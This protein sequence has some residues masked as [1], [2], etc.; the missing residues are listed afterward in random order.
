MTRSSRL[1]VALRSPLLLAVVDEA[2]AAGA[3]VIRGPIGRV[4]LLYLILMPLWLALVGSYRRRLAR[5][6]QTDLVPLLSA[7]ACPLL[8]MALIRTFGTEMLLKDMPLVVGLVVL[9]RAVTY[10]VQRVARSRSTDAE[11]TLILG[12]GKLGCQVAEALLQHPEYGMKPVGFVDGFPNDSHLPLPVVGDIDTFD[13]TVRRVGAVRV[14]V[15]FGA[16]REA[17]LVDVLRASAEAHVEVHILPRLFELGVT[18]TG[19]E[20]DIVWGL[21]LQHARRAALRTPAWRTKRV[22]D[23]AVSSVALFLLWPLLA[24]VALAVR[25]TSRGPVLFRQKRLGQRGQVVEIYK[26][27]S[28]RVTTDGD[29]RWGNRIDDRVTRVGRFLR[30]TSMDE[31]PQLL[32]VLKGD[33]SLV[34]PR[35]E[36]PFF[37]DQFNQQVFRYRDRL[38][39]PVGLTGWAQVHGLRGDTSIEE[40]ARFDNYYIEHWSLWF[41]LVILGRTVGQV[42]REMTSYLR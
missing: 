13:Q 4:G 1:W 2:A 9:G 36:R 35:P 14:I 7:L 41:D 22:I 42:V 27:R 16:N 15:A 31:L 6:F 40:R 37:A 29:T 24:G 10:S 11:P 26:F 39:V 33:M 38:R 8:L 20:S 12:A 17:E 23:V 34:G 5:G 18:S 25:L 21:P 3:L 30:V 19:P 32:N 28:M